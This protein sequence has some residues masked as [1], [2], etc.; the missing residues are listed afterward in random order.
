MK[1]SFW[2]QDTFAVRGQSTRRNPLRPVGVFLRL[3]ALCMSGMG[4]VVGLLLCLTI[5]GLIP[6]VP[7]IVMSVML[8]NMV[9]G[10]R[11]TGYC[12]WC[13]SEIEVTKKRGGIQCK[14]CK[15]SCAI[16]DGYLMKIRNQ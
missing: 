13:S 15:R 16:A 4:F 3:C 10:Y 12:P 7:M 14:N 6:G 1:E 9:F 2:H 8:L 5:I 11:A